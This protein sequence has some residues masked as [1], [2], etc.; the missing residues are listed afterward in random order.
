MHVLGAN[1]LFSL[2][3]LE[4]YNGAIRGNAVTF[5]AQIKDRESCIG[6]RNNVFY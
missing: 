2:N 5:S 3:S 6:D 1:M 4:E